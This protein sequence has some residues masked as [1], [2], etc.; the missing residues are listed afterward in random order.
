[1]LSSL[2]FN[3]FKIKNIEEFQ[4]KQYEEWKTLEK[5]CY[6]SHITLEHY[7]HTKVCLLYNTVEI[8]LVEI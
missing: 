5:S 3:E 4:K 1:M 6:R 7:K 2:N 8:Q